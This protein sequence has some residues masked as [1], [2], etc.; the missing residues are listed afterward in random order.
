MLAERLPGRRWSRSAIA[1]PCWRCT[2]AISKCSHAPTAP[3][4]PGRRRRAP[5]RSAAAAHATRERRPN[6]TLAPGGDSPHLRPMARSPKSPSR[7]TRAKA[8]KPELKPLDEHLAAL[9]SPAINRERESARGFGEAPQA[10]FDAGDVTPA[11]PKLA[12][13]LGLGRPRQAEPPPEGEIHPGNRKRDVGLSRDDILKAAPKRVR[14]GNVLRDEEEDEQLVRNGLGGATAT[15]DSLKSLLEQGDPNLRQ[16]SVWSPHRPPR[17]EKSEGG[18]AFEIVSEFEPKGDQP[19]AIAELVEGVARHERDQ[20]LLGVTGSGKTFTM[21]QVIARTNRP[22]S[23]SRRTRRSRRSFTASSR[24]SSRTTRSSISSPT[25]T[26]TSPRPMCRGR[27]PTSRRNPR[28]TSRS[29]ACA[30][31]PRARCW[32]ATT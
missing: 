8:S 7:P 25:T 21:A 15:V 18:I 22:R 3:S 10:G 16:A 12:R 29:T 11:D 17:P 32:S 31:R 19:T 6:A 27:T 26:T 1:R 23:S 24:A 4:P 2:R 13:S 5:P 14:Q 30:T 9:L 20:V 28:S